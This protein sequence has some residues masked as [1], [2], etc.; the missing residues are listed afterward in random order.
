M[1]L[2]PRSEADW[3]N[4]LRSC[5]VDTITAAKF[6]PAFAMEIRDLSGGEDELDDFLGQYLHETAMLTRM[7]E[8]L[9]YSAKGLMDTWPSRF[10]LDTAVRYAKAGQQAI[11]NKV[12]ADRMGNGDEASGDGWDFRGR[13]MGITGRANY[14]RLGDMMGQDLVGVPTLLEGPIY[15]TQAARMW[16]EGDIP[17]SFLNDIVKTTR[18]LNG[19]LIGI[20]HRRIVTDAATRALR[21]FA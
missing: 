11:A 3:E 6:A 17:D 15:A 7:T 14:E 19:G 13:G 5:G 10:D 8:N 18:R 9:R 12:Y 16:W 1:K 2:K 4:I 20:A 21:E